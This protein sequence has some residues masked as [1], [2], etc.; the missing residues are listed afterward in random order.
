MLKHLSDVNLVSDIEEESD[1]QFHR[2]AIEVFSC[3]NPAE[4]K[5]DS[6]SHLPDPS[7]AHPKSKFFGVQEHGNSS[8]RVIRGGIITAQQAIS[9]GA[10][11]RPH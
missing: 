8:V 1:E 2:S 6:S 11:T 5:T 3:I 9:A 7:N 10:G 4:Q